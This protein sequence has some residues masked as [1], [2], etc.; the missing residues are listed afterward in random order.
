MNGFELIIGLPYETKQTH[1]EA[2]KKLID[3]D[4]EIWNYNLH[5]LLALKWIQQEKIIY[6]NRLE[7]LR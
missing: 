7:V 5:L 1:I 6:K 2:N 4:F 3:L